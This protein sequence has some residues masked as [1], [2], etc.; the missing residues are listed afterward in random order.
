MEIT[1]NNKNLGFVISDKSLMAEWLGWASQGHAMY[2]Y[3]LQVIG[4]NPGW[5][6]LRVCNTSV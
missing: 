6:E 5:V 2:F 1:S 3:D 4:L